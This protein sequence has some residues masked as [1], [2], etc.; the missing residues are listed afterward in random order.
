MFSKR[1]IAF[2]MALLMLSINV[3]AVTPDFNLKRGTTFS[4]RVISPIN[5]KGKGT[6]SA[7]VDN[8][9]YGS[10]GKVLIK[11]GETVQLQVQKKKAKG[12]GRAGYVSVNCVSTTAT[13]GQNISLSGVIEDEGNKKLGLALGLGIGLGLTVLP[14]VG[15]AFLA[16]KGE[17]ANIETNTLIPSVTVMGD[18]AIR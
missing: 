11:R 16:I 5:S 14:I 9:V 17:Q 12:C 7:V 8:D 3:F 15:F 4:V 6:P 1:F 13:D 2:F 10:D 18:Y